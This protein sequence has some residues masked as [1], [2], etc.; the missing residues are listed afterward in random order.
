[1]VGVGEIDFGKPEIT[2][3]PSF[4]EPGE[5]V[6]ANVSSYAQM[7]KGSNFI[8]ILDGIEV[9]NSK[10]KNSV[11]FTAGEDNVAQKLSAVFQTPDG[12]QVVADFDF[13]PR[14]LDIIIEPQTHVPSFYLGRPLPSVGSLVNATFLISGVESYS[15]LLFTWRMGREVVSEGAVRGMNY[16]SF[17]TSLDPNIILTV[18][19]RDT[20]G[21]MVAS[22]IVSIPSAEPFIKFY[23]SNALLGLA[24]KPVNGALTMLGNIATLRSE[25]YYLDSRTYNEPDLL[26]WKVDGVLYPNQNQNPYEV[27]L[28]KNSATGRSQLNFHVRDLSQLLQGARGGVG[29]N[30]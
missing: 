15:D 3:K 30:L 26:E 24:N 7:V 13:L 14:Y 9:P 1:M 25:P 10:N 4:P 20:N 8:W 6:T 16:V 28:E 29:I 11:T 5:T 2:I 21:E 23:E 12:R 17:E 18:E 22:E 27:T 19:A